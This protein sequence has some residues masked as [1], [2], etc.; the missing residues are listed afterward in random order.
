LAAE[1]PI[2]EVLVTDYGAKCDGV[3]DDTAAFNAALAALPTGAQN[4]LVAGGGTIVVPRGICI[5]NNWT[6][7]KSAV[8][9]RGMGHGWDFNN[10]A[11][12][13]S[14]LKGVSGAPAVVTIPEVGIFRVVLRDLTIHGGGLPVGVAT[15][16]TGW[17]MERVGLVG[18][19]RQL[20]NRSGA[21]NADSTDSGGIFDSLVAGNIRLASASIRVERTYFNGLG[22][23]R[24]AIN[25]EG[26][27]PTIGTT[28]VVIANNTFDS[29]GGPILDIGVVQTVRAITI[30]GNF[31]SNV[32]STG[33]NIITLGYNH[34]VDGASITGNYFS[35]ADYALGFR[36]DRAIAATM[37]SGLTIKSNYFGGRYSG[38]TGAP[39]LLEA[40]SGDTVVEANSGG[41]VE[42]NGYRSE[43]VTST[44]RVKANVS[45]NSIGTSI[46]KGVTLQTSTGTRAIMYEVPIAPT[47]AVQVRARVV[48]KADR[49]MYSFIRTVSA[50]NNG[51]G[52]TVAGGALVEEYTYKD[53]PAADCTFVVF[54]DQL[55][56][57]VAGAAN[58]NVAW[59][60]DLEIIRQ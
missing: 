47:E 60:A 24:S 2:Y 1:T 52:A 31:F 51:A 33:S 18:A 54:G 37:V 21:I 6:I 40:P 5:V 23:I 53:N 16:G 10:H 27:S 22:R 38:G 7:S 26:I 15:V 39:I 48:G 32:R 57:V 3:T 34:G 45:Y 35:G 19:T 58:T 12:P 41:S 43:A 8:V 49:G 42:W 17:R 28:S 11:P 55:Q 25:V 44:H 9:V 59:W 4:D 20:D 36:V 46:I 13:A 30:S 56:M 50:R 14:V 29:Y